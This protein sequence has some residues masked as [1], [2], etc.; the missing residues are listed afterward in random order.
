MNADAHTEGQHQAARHLIVGAGL[1]PAYRK[2]NQIDQRDHN[3]NPAH[4]RMQKLKNIHANPLFVDE[5][6]RQTPV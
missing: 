2:I 5:Q 3:D 1:Q 6:I 4:P